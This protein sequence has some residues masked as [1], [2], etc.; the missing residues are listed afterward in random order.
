MADGDLER[1]LRASSVFGCLEDGDRRRLAAAG[2][3]RHYQPRQTIF[4]KH[5]AGSFML[6]VLSGCVRVCI[7]SSEGREIALNLI[8][9]GEVLGEIAV[10]DGRARTADAVAIDVVEA[11]VLDRRDLLALLKDRPAA[12]VAMLEM[13]CQRLRRTSGQVEALAFH[14]LPRR[15][16]MLLLRLADDT[17]VAT[18]DGVRIARPLAQRD[19]A[20]LIGSTRESVN[21]QLRTWST[22][23][24]IASDRGY[25]T[26]RDFD[27]L[28]LVVA[29]EVD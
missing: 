8:Q 15:L 3:R 12:A 17:G 4:Q 28:S 7:Y 10:L 14:D 13:L 2:Q 26:I 21:R 23:E 5:D 27:A 22:E 16:A 24:I 6:A 20:R 9:P 1:M 18:P 29:D 11:L 19:L 25:I